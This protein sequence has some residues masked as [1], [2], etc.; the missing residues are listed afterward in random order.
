MSWKKRGLIALIIAAALG[1][2]IYGIKKMKERLP[3]Y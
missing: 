3:Y 1:G 2:A